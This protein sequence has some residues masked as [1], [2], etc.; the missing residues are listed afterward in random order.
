MNNKI[1]VAATTA[2]RGENTFTISLP[3]EESGIFRQGW[4]PEELDAVTVIC[5][6]QSDVK[7]GE[8]AVVALRGEPNVLL[9]YVYKSSDGTVLE[10]PKNYD[11]PD[12]HIPAIILTEDAAKETLTIL[13][14][15][16]KFVFVL[17]GCSLHASTR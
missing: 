10:A 12:E 13:G 8:L 11:K 2:E 7:R 17:S 6:R 5:K 15:V 9:K 16:E 3:V 4:K 14:K 1:N